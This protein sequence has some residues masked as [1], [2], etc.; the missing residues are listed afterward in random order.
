MP[1][2]DAVRVAFV[3]PLARALPAKVYVIDGSDRTAEPNAPVTGWMVIVPLVRF[4]NP[5]EPTEVPG[6]P[7]IGATVAIGR[8]LLVVG[9][10]RTVL[11]P[12][13]VV[14]PG[15]IRTAPGKPP[16]M[17]PQNFRAPN[18]PPHPD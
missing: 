10:P 4:P 3:P 8:A 7:R 11:P 12:I 14:P 9:F 2:F 13:D 16:A 1:P 15:G 18:C 17:E 6:I 5:T